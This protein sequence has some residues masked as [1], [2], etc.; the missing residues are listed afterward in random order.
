MPWDGFRV[1]AARLWLYADVDVAYWMLDVGPW[2]IVLMACFEY[3][4]WCCIGL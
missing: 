4:F 3:G 1:V 2:L